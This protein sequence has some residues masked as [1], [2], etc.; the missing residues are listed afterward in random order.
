MPMTIRNICCRCMVVYAA[1]RHNSP[2]PLCTPHP[3]F[4][5]L[6]AEQRAAQK[7]RL[8]QRALIELAE[9]WRGVGDDKQKE[10]KA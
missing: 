8:W 6:W 4:G 5:G 3:I 9:L 1:E 7:R 2:C 10:T